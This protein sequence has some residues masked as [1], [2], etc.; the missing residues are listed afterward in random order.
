MTMLGQRGKTWLSTVTCLLLLTVA[1]WPVW[2]N[3]AESAF[4]IS[5][6]WNLPIMTVSAE[7]PLEAQMTSEPSPAPPS[8][9]SQ[10]FLRQI[11]PGLTPDQ[12][13]T[14]LQLPHDF[15]VSFRYHGDSSTGVGNR[16]LQPPL[17]FQYSMDY[18]LLPKLQVGLSGFLYQPPGD[19]L[20][21]LRQGTDKLVL[22]WGPSLR[23]DLGRWSFTFRS[24]VQRGGSEAGKDL[25]NWFRVWYAF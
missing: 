12:H 7:T 24:Q 6:A 10:P 16:M 21:F 15:R 3:A 9:G 1:F 22:G 23:Y 11:S 8:F 2:G 19:N 5:P 4:L 18:C 14:T 20:S 17:L 13:G 25:Q